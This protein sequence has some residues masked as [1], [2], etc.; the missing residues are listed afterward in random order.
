MKKV[1]FILV[2][3][4]S[5]FFWGNLFATPIN[6]SDTANYWP[7]WGGGVRTWKHSIKDNTE[8]HIGTPDIKGGQVDINNGEIN[9]VTIDYY[10]SAYY[11]DVTPGDLFIDLGSDKYWD[12]VIQSASGTILGFGTKEFALGT[13]DKNPNLN[14]GYDQNYQ[15]SGDCDGYDGSGPAFTGV[16]QNPDGRTYDIRDDHPVL[17]HNSGSLNPRT[18]G[19]A[20]VGSF[21]S[22]VGSHSFMFSNLA[23]LDLK[24]Y[25]SFTIGWAVDCANDVLY[26]K[27]PAPVPEPGTMMLLGIGLMLIGPLMRKKRGSKE[28]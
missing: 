20:S 21:D 6:F 27:V 15:L 2:L 22:S 4:T 10:N 9:S 14:Y 1:T 11:G 26:E 5:L 17:Y 23:G 25:D 12:Y 7:G 18:L 28:S 19:S 24:G 13:Y 8:E 16:W 3:I